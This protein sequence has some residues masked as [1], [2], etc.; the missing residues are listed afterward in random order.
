MLWTTL[1]LA[2]LL[3]AASFNGQSGTDFSVMRQD[4]EIMRRI[5][6]REALGQTQEQ[7]FF[8]GYNPSTAG[9][10]AFFLPGGGALFVLRTSQSVA[11]GPNAGKKA[12]EEPTMWEKVKGELDGKPV[13]TPEEASKYDRD[14][15]ETLQRKVLDSLASNV[16]NMSQLE[17]SAPITVVVKGGPAPGSKQSGYLE[18]GVRSVL[19]S[20]QFRKGVVASVG[21]DCTVLSLRITMADAQ[22]YAAGKLTLPEFRSRAL[23]AQY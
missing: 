4:L 17:G 7:V 5:L 10:E 13:V 16:A 1:V 6:E 20:D 11:P 9:A 12:N 2:T 15:V 19:L 22:A 14:W 23:I 21:P 8:L 3:Q 18:V